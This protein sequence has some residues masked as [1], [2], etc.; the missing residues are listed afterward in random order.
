MRVVVAAK[1]VP[2]KRPNTKPFDCPRGSVVAFMKYAN[3]KTTSVAPLVQML[4]LPENSSSLRGTFVTVSIACVGFEIF[5]DVITNMSL[6]LS[7]VFNNPFCQNTSMV[8][9]VDVAG[10][11][12]TV[13][14][15]VRLKDLLPLAINK[16]DAANA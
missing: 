5:N 7:F 13:G 10:L 12:D 16:F 15:V 9:V 11:A 14:V 4:T 6:F 3:N 2:T 8:A 1:A